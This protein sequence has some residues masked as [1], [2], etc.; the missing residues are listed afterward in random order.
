MGFPHRLFTLHAS[1]HH[2]LQQPVITLEHRPL[3]KAGLFQLALIIKPEQRNPYQAT[4]RLHRIQMHKGIAFP[5]PDTVG[6]CHILASPQGNSLVALGEPFGVRCHVFTNCHTQQHNN[7]R[8]LHGRPDNP[9]Q[10]HP[11]GANH[12]QLR[13]TR[14]G[15][16]PN[17]APHKRPERQV[18]VDPAGQGE[19]HVP[20]RLHRLVI[21]AGVFQLGNEG[22]DY[23][24]RQHY[25]HHQEHGTTNGAHYIVVDLTH[26]RGPPSPAGGD[27][28]RPARN[29][30][31]TLAPG[32]A[33]A[34]RA[35]RS[36][37]APCRL[38]VRPG[39][40]SEGPDR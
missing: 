2:V 37:P 30:A 12:R 7:Q 17:Q 23:I 15:P 13:R 14:H 39:P 16:Q 27:A 8:R 3:G 33:R 24:Q 18:I 29:A 21:V 34:P 19:R 20:K 35:C 25:H 28:A 22:E 6:R 1:D 10:R 11:G 5:M 26:W 40:R 31:I 4:I 32:T 9:L 38:P 36:T